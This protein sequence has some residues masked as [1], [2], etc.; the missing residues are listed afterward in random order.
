MTNKKSKKFIVYND[1]NK[2]NSFETMEDAIEYADNL[3]CFMRSSVEI[4]E[5]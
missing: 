4:K 5:E 1:D 2:L 3:P